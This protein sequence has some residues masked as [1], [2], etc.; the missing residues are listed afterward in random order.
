MICVRLSSSEARYSARTVSSTST[1]GLS[2]RNAVWRSATAK[3]GYT[4]GRIWVQGP[5]MHELQPSLEEPALSADWNRFGFDVPHRKQK[6]E[7]DTH[8]TNATQWAYYHDLKDVDKLFAWLDDRGVRECALRKELQVFRDRIV[9]YMLIMKKHLSE[10][11]RREKKDEDT[12][13]RTNARSQTYSEKAAIRDYR[14]RWTNSIMRNEYGHNHSEEYELQ[15]AK[16]M[17]GAK[18]KRK[19]G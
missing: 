17:E 1:T 4:N 10:A 16:A 15:K 12:T 19:R 2:K 11:E 9:E 18:T 5:D 6:E 14:V 13:S 8:L 3:Y 7:G